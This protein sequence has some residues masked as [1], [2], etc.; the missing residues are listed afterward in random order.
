MPLPSLEVLNGL[1]A[2]V[3][4][5]A[6]GAAAADIAVLSGADS[7]EGPA[8]SA[9]KAALPDQGG[10]KRRPGDEDIVTSQP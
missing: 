1:L 6:A 2:V 4:V 3:G 10:L 9:V 7:L 8:G 5:A